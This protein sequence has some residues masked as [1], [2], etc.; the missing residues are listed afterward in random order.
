MTYA[1]VCCKICEVPEYRAVM[2]IC[3]LCGALGDEPYIELITI[4]LYD[5]Y[6]DRLADH[7]MFATPMP[8]IQ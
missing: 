2:T 4:Q 1:R 5:E 6:C 8:V 3:P 7:E